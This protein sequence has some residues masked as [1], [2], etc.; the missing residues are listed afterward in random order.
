MLRVVRVMLSKKANFAN[1][2]VGNDAKTASA[3]DYGLTELDHSVS[4]QLRPWV[5]VRSATGAL[6][7]ANDA[8]A[9]FATAVKYYAV[10]CCA[11]SK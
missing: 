6:L 5:D 4:R 11:K 2:A 1:H 9:K 7:V 3:A 10:S 8:V